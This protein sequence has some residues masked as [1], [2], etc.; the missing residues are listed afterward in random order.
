MNNVIW[1]VAR[2][3]VV[4]ITLQSGALAMGQADLPAAAPDDAV[5]ASP[6]EVTEVLD[7][8]T[9]AFTG[10]RPPGAPARAEL[11]VR[12]Q[13]HNVLCFGESCME[14][15]IKIGSRA[16]K[17]GLGT[18][19][20]SE[21]VVTLPK[22]TKAFKAF[23][24][25]DNNDDTR[26]KHGSVEFVVEIGGKEVFRSPTLRGGQEPAEV[27][28]DVPDGTDRIVLK[29]DATPDGVSHD[30]ADWA[31]AHLV[32]QDGKA[33]WLDENQLDLLLL[34]TDPPF[35]FVYGGVASAELLKGWQRTFETK[36][37]P[38]RI[39]HV[40]HWT[41]PKTR[42]RVA[43][44]VGVFKRYPA[45]DWVLS[46]ENQG[47]G[48]TPIIEQI[49]AL[50]VGLR[51]GYARRAGIL[52]HLMGDACAERTFLPVE[53]DV[54]AGQT[55]RMAPTG[56]R[57]SSISA[58]PFF[59]F[60][61]RDRGIITAVGWS[62]QWAA[63]FDRAGTGPTRL[64]AG[65]EQTHFL[66]HPG[67]KIRTPRILLLAWRGDRQAAHNRFRRLMLFHYLPKQE[68]K[69]ARLP[70]ALQCFDRYSW[71]NP[72]WATEAGQI[73]GAEFAKK[74]GCDHHWL[75]AAWFVG[76][77]PNGVGNWFCKPKEFPNGLKPVSDA[78][79]ELGLRFVL[80]F[81]PERVAPG[82]E[83]ARE[84]PE[85][86]FG[87]AKG[88]LFKLNDPAARRWLT[89]LL[90]KRIAE[91]GVDVYRND[92]NIDPL[93]FWRGNDAPDRQGMTEIRYVE[94][95]YEMWD[96]LLSR[97]P[98]LLIDNCSSGGRRIDLET[99]MR[100]VPLWRSDT[101][102]SPG[103]PDWNQAQTHA[104]SLYVPFHTAC[105]WTPEPYDFR[106]SATG[107]AICQF[108]Y[109]D[110]DFPV[111]LAKATIAEA[112]ENS[113]FW[114]GDFYPLTPCTTTPDHWSAYQ[115][116]RPDL[117]AG[118]VLVFR[119]SESRYTGLEL[120]LNGLAKGATYEVEF[121]DN[122][123]AKTVKTM[124]GEALMSGMELRLPKRP[125]SMLVRYRPRK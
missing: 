1:A 106:S 43:A 53:S 113:A 81:E 122:A 37:R 35:S 88:G 67:E 95:H 29:V 84:H 98:G 36:D 118:L 44:T 69:P 96:E 83:I 52:H 71:T 57:P 66:L 30:Q 105:G 47:T 58:F 78:C 125:G 124:T 86:V 82:T 121:I 39:E 27:S 114:Y 14:T 45:V 56:G 63:S 116:H 8:A 46:L 110:A 65:M 94:G 48:D 32:M 24:G 91:Y 49:Q 10:T 97:H 41:D 21:I 107:G 102:C 16:F 111:E 77:F 28:V 115:F 17:H 103:H 92:F 25:I 99:C 112:R 108:A 42:L 31:D 5:M 104:L 51:T 15:P 55:L 7:W 123:R 73:A 87:G 9:V 20:N 19:A 93:G 76:G 59:N 33:V 38:D 79:H 100:S 119:R 13:D 34:N 26:G 12:R 61:Y 11:E 62:G 60:Q 72:Q 120:G 101:S 109:L 68:G 64:R 6:A 85:F 80:W 23:V 75:D 18:H 40:V 4:L 90:S 3:F 22:G 117:G 70:F 2:A 89:E 74:V 54:Q 50:D